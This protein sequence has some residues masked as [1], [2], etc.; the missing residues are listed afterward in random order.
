MPFSKS[1]DLQV[2]LWICLKSPRQGCRKT[3]EARFAKHSPGLI[4]TKRS[5]FMQAGGSPVGTVLLILV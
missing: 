5:I 4:E 1:L 3:N 2:L